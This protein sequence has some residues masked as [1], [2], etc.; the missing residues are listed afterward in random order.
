MPFKPKDNSSSDD[1]DKL[2]RLVE[3]GV[4]LRKGIAMG[5]MDDPSVV[6]HGQSSKPKPSVGSLGGV[7]KGGKGAY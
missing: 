6:E 1:A 3:K 2:D 7:R 4:R 5:G